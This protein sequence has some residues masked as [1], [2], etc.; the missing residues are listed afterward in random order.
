M[1]RPP[2]GW[3]DFTYEVIK[4]VVG[5]L[6]AL[7]AG[8]VVDAYNWRSDVRATREALNAEIAVNAGYALDRLAINDCMR[9]RLVSLADK[10][11]S[12]QPWAG[13]PLL[14]AGSAGKARLPRVYGVPIR[15]WPTGSWTA[16]MASGAVAH[17]DRAEAQLYATVYRQ[18]ELLRDTQGQEAELTPNLA[19][20]AFDQTLDTAQMNAMTQTLTR[21]DSLNNLQ[22]AVAGQLLPLLGPLGVLRDPANIELINLYPTGQREAR[23]RCVHLLAVSSDRR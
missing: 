15:P 23:G 11:R 3:S 21:L 8:A 18:I 12:G 20:L 13:D 4:I 5:V 22:F 19:P 6:I 14:L 17:M 1:W 7:G 2:E 9:D 10:L 16:A